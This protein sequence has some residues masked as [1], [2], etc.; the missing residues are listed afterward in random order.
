MSPKKFKK[1]VVLYF[2]WSL[3][4]NQ[5]KEKSN[6]IGGNLQYRVLCQNHLTVDFIGNKKGIK[7]NKR[8]MC[9]KKNPYGFFLCCILCSSIRIFISRQLEWVKK[10]SFSC[11][12]SFSFCHYVVLVLYKVSYPF[13]LVEYLDCY[14]ERASVWSNNILKQTKEHYKC[15]ILSAYIHTY[16]Y[17]HTH[18]CIYMHTNVYKHR[19]SFFNGTSRHCSGKIVFF[20]LDLC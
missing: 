17:I 16:M 18:M 10:T 8:K 13:Y 1:Y 2:Q 11:G 4:I 3:C 5:Q 20:T 7:L 15:T 6:S 19:C 14:G 9:L 12:S